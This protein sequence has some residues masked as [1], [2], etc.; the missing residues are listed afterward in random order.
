MSEFCW[1]NWRHYILKCS[2]SSSSSSL[3]FFLITFRAGIISQT[4]YLLT[5]PT[6]TQCTNCTD[7]GLLNVEVSVSC[8]LFWYSLNNAYNLLFAVWA[9]TQSSWK[10]YRV[11][12]NYTD[13]QNSV[14][15]YVTYQCEFIFLSLAI[16]LLMALDPF[17]FYKNLHVKWVWNNT[18]TTVYIHTYI[19]LL[20]LWRYNSERVL[21]FSTIA[22][23]F[24]AVLHL[25]C[26]LH[27]LHLLHIIPD[28]IIPSRLGPSSWSSYEWFP[29]VYSFHYA[30]FRHSICVSKPTPL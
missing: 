18:N 24:R 4:L 19:S 1:W 3:F 27:K 14:K 9:L 15:I 30:G 6:S 5:Y 25:F 12:H 20:L 26:P 28:I 21:A 11:S 16:H 17:L 7:S 29:L 10:R 8:P 23:L 13:D 22:F 2:S